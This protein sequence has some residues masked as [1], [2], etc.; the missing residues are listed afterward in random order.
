MDLI[1]TIICSLIYC[2][3]S[4]FDV[5]F[6]SKPY[7]NVKSFMSFL[8]LFNYCISIVLSSSGTMI[9]ATITSLYSIVILPHR[10][11]LLNESYEKDG[12]E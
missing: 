11:K 7:V 12:D 2:E 8:S 4:W 6:G 5:K 1:F 9:F 10:Y 3:Y